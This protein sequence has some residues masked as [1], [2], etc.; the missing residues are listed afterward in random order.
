M[1]SP[2]FPSKIRLVASFCSGDDPTF[3]LTLSALP[4]SNACRGFPDEILIYS[5]RGGSPS[6]SPAWGIHFEYVRLRVVKNE[7]YLH[8]HYATREFTG[9]ERLV[10]IGRRASPEG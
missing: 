1:G 8:P 2:F 9:I 10:G 5:L 4:L 7:R 3:P 6:T